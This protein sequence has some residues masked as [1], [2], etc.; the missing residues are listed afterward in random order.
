MNA[1]CGETL[2][3]WAVTDHGPEEIERFATV[4]EAIEYC[5]QYWPEDNHD[6]AIGND[7]GR[8]LAY[9]AHGKDPAECLVFFANG[10]REKYRCEYVLGDHGRIISNVE[11]LV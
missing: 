4:E 7:L 8:E 9:M 10:D 3:A 6:V 5:L 11:R 1:I 2:T